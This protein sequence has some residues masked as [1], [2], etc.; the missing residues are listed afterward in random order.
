MSSI[1]TGA[2]EAA[3]RGDTVSVMLGARLNFTSGAAAY[4][5]GIGPLDATALGGPVFTGVGALGAISDTIEI[6]TQ[7]ATEQLTLTL[8]G[9]DVSILAKMENQENEVQG[10]RAEIYYLTFASDLSAGRPEMS[11]VSCA[12]RRTLIMDQMPLEAGPV[13]G[14]HKVA[15]SVICEPLLAS[16]NRAP[17][18]FLTNTDQ[19]RRYPGDRVC[20]R[21]QQLIQKQSMVFSG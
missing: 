9:L 18:A 21:V 5:N 1:F 10:R 2:I 20:E 7:A 13:E 12:K 4:W 14:G 19:Q 8:S 11:L 15:I 6:G 16:K 17:W 3:I